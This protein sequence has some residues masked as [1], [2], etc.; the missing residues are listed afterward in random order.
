LGRGFYQVVWEMEVPHWG[1]GAKPW[2][3]VLGTKPV[4]LCKL[5]YDDVL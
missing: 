4:T 2:K 5:Y 1:P 3:R